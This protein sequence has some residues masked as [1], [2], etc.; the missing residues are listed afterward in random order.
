LLY[1]FGCFCK[2]RFNF[3]GR[4]FPFLKEF[5]KGLKIAKLVL[6]GFI[7]VG[8]DLNRFNFPQDA[9][10]FFGVIP[11]TGG[12]GLLFGFYYLRFFCVIVKGTSSGPQRGLLNLLL[13]RSS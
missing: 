13:G 3:F 4:A 10:G 9:F 7:I 8:P 2:L 6:Y 5:V 12:S 11:E 1:R